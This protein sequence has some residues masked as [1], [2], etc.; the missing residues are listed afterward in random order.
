MTDESIE[1]SEVDNLASSKGWK[2]ES[3]WEGNPTD[4][5]PAREFL[6]RGE[7]MDRISDQTRQ[8]KTQNDD[9]AHLKATVKSLGDHNRKIAEKEYEKAL[10]DLK[11]QK[12]KALEAFDHETV[13]DI[14][15]KIDDLKDTKAAVEKVKMVPPPQP[16]ADQTPREVT[17]WITKNNWYKE[18]IIL[19]GAV[20]SLSNDYLE[21][22][23][24][25]REHI[26]E[27]L[28]YIDKKIREEFP[29][30]FDKQQRRPTATTEPG[31]SV[32]RT[33]VNSKNS[34]HTKKDLNDM[35]R[36]FCK[37]L[38][39]EGALTEQE[40]IDQIAELGDLDIQRGI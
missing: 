28:S 40:Y 7:L 25:A 1:Q 16:Q 6:D 35:Q 11:G 22:N 9:V 34:K 33:K 29:H 32:A 19:R 2:P 24:N 14:D 8:L 27:V 17:D 31:E 37:T 18:D 20:D 12:A 21:R 5:R 10:K 30:K 38:V 4:W 15:D 36:T 3:D 26:P 13:V 39:E 23:P